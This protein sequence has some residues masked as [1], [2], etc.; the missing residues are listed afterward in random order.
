MWM[1][2][3]TLKTV[4]SGGAYISELDS[5]TGLK[6]ARREAYS[7]VTDKYDMGPRRI[8]IDCDGD[9]LEGI[10]EKD[11]R[12]S[13]VTWHTDSGKYILNSD[14]SLGRRIE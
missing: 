7:Y 1:T 13:R 12:Y 8:Y 3:Y 10:V 2:K 4:G 14:G 6:R 11:I 9:Y 5:F